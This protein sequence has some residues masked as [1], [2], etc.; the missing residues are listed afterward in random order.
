MKVSRQK[1]L[2]R[3]FF[4]AV[5][6][7]WFERTYDPRREYRKFPS[8][9]VRM[10]VALGEIGRFGARGPVLDVGCG[11]GELV[12]ALLKQKRRTVGIDVSGRMIDIARRNLTRSRIS[13]DPAKTFIASDLDQF[14]PAGRAVFRAATALGLLEYLETDGALFAFLRRVLARRGLAFVECRNKFFNLFS[15]NRYTADLARRKG[16]AELLAE[17]VGADRFSRLPASAIPPIYAG[18]LRRTSAF[19]ARAA[20]DRAWLDTRVP[21]YSAY[22]QKMVR[23]QHTPGQLARS[24]DR[25]GFKLRYVVYWHAHPFPPSYEKRFPR[26]FNRLAVL[27]G[28]LGHTPLGAWLCSSFL[29]VLE[30]VR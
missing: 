15:Q 4:D 29:A 26:I 23:R 8:N 14:R 19:L 12:I 22:P 18:V 2:T 21:A 5:S 9:R 10:E 7:E 28:P 11:T 6:A 13:A 25:F 16:F 17:F 3:E 24:A 20:H 30:R 1:R 27:M